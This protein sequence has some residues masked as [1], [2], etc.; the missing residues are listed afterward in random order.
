MQ[1]LGLEEVGV[2]LTKSGA[3]D[4]DAY[5]RSSVSSASLI[6]SLLV[7]ASEPLSSQW[8]S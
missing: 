7:L 5:S 1:G 4:V 8:R 3:I 6:A 2:K